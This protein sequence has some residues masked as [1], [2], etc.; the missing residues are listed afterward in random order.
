MW[1]GEWLYAPALQGHSMHRRQHGRKYRQ[2]L[3]KQTHRSQSRRGVVVERCDKT[4]RLRRA[5]R[6]GDNHEKHELIA[7]E[8]GKP[9]EI[10][11]AVG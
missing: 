1:G 5:S 8:K 6:E 3:E 11:G 10:K 4:K 2:L 7:V 9:A